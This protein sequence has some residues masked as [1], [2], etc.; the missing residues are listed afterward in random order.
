MAPTP[1]RAAL[2]ALTATSAS[3]SV[4]QREAGVG[5]DAVAATPLVTPCSTPHL[6][7]SSGPRRRCAGPQ[8]PGPA[9]SA[10]RDML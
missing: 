5:R 2:L 10:E 4:G 1:P 8:H 7:A 6:A 9:S 3:C